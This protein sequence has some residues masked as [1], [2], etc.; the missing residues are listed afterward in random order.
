MDDRGQESWRM[1]VGG[2]GLWWA[3][4]GD[5]PG[6]GA[7]LDDGDDV[8]PIARRAEEDRVEDPL[9]GLAD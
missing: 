7:A 6:F 2:A 8:V 3:I 1:R 5:I 9:L 4:R